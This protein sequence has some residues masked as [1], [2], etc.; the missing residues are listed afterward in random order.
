MTATIL[1]SSTAGPSTPVG[2][3]RRRVLMLTHRLPYPPD[4]GDRIR[5]YHLLKLL[6]AHFDLAVAC[7]SDEPVWLQ[8]HQLL[9]TMARRVAIHPTHATLSK[10]L[11]VA[12]LL[13]G[14]PITPACHYRHGLAET[15]LQW[16]EQ[17]PFDA[18]LTFCTGMID[19]ARLLTHPA[20]PRSGQ[21]LV[22]RHVLDLV[23]VDSLKWESYARS[24]W[25]P[26]RWVY[27]AEARR[28][29][30]IESGSQD[31]FDA[32]TVVSRHEADSYRQ[33]VGD[34]P[35]LT[36]VPNGVDLEYFSPLPDAPGKRLVFVGVLNYWPN[37]QG[38]AWFVHQVMPLLRQREPDIQLQI[39]GRHPTPAVRELGNQKGV[40]VVGSVPGRSRVSPPRDRDHRSAAHCPRGAE[41]GTGGDGL[42]PHRGMLTGRRT[43][44]RRGGRRAFP[45]R[46]LP[47]AM[48]RP[49]NPFAGRCPTAGSA[50][51]GR[52][53]ICGA[54]TIVGR[55]VWN[56]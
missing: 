33:T 37:A 3:A 14:K 53:G 55:N 56:P 6:A 23:D 50:G 16:Q 11:G 51:P 44:D 43:R 8:H 22:S 49:F 18:V 21:K 19:Y 28:L 47:R 25:P 17:Q 30:R 54:E 52:Q 4:R 40:E 7:T 31:H 39:V 13:R 38:I 42:R 2:S 15:I 12:A 48:G 1:P 5:S 9:M 26:Q 27:G 35:G 36:V 24:S 46:R 10:M 32:V 29:R 20:R 45:G 34:H 41:Q